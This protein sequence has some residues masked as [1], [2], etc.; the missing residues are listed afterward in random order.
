MLTAANL[1]ITQP[2]YKIDDDHGKLAFTNSPTS[3]MITEKQPI[4]VANT[5]LTLRQSGEIIA[6]NR[7]EPSAQHSVQF[8]TRFNALE[9]QTAIALGPGNF[10]EKVAVRSELGRAENL[11]LTLDEEPVGAPHRSAGWQLSNVFR[12]GH[13]LLV[14]RL[15]ANGTRQNALSKRLLYVSALRRLE[16]K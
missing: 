8:E 10:A 13:R 15:D 1:S 9:D 5:I 6:T 4:N 11:I 16:L 7:P 2:V 3:D 14:L 12:G